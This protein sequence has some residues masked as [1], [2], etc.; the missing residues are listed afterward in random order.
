MKRSENAIAIYKT[1]YFNPDEIE[2]EQTHKRVAECIGN[3]KTQIEIFEE[4]LNKNIF[5]PNSPCLINARSK[6]EAEKLEDHD[7]N[8]VNYGHVVDMC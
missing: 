3:N 8:L 5:R 4:M 1:L 7:N 6:E 2:P